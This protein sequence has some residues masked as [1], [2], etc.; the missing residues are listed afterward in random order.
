[1]GGTVKRL[2]T[3]CAVAV[4]AIAAAVLTGSCNNNLTWW[5]QTWAGLDML[6][7]QGGSL[8]LGDDS[9]PLSDEYPAHLVTLSTFEMSRYE[10]TQELYEFITGDNPS[11][12]QAPLYLDEPCRPVEYV[13]WQEAIEFCNALSSYAG[14][15]LCYTIDAS[16]P[17]TVT[18]DTSANGYRLPTEAEWEFAARGGPDS[19]GYPYPGSEDPRD[20]AW[21]NDNSFGATHCV[22]ELGSNELDFYDMGGNVAEWC[23]DMKSDDY[24]YTSDWINPLGPSGNVAPIND[25]VWFVARGGAYDMPGLSARNATRISF[26]DIDKS[27]DLGFRVARNQ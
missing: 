4:L 2:V 26:W 20:V 15:D 9:N 1:V 11:Y 13:S 24:W 17:G 14:L 23:W 21:Y 22:G 27:P 19:Y 18:W 3:A 12:Y 16:I 5:L 7:V 25:S 10:V 6:E 8:D